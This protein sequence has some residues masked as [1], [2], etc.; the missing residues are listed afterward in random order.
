MV[1]SFDDIVNVTVQ[2][3]FTEAMH[4]SS[5]LHYGHK[6]EDIILAVQIWREEIMIIMRRLGQTLNTEKVHLRDQ[7]MFPAFFKR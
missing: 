6:G 7:K 5:L 4:R 2:C 3:K 1:S